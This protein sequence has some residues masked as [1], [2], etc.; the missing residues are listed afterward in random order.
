MFK[1]DML[2]VFMDKYLM[3][4]WILYVCFHVFMDV[5]YRFD[6][7][8]DLQGTKPLREWPSIASQQIW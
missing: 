1:I 7:S 5:A 4:T 6:S 3:F 2:D 8:M